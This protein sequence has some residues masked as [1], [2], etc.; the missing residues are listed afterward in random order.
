MREAW[1]ELRAVTDPLAVWLDHATVERPEAVVAK[2]DLLAAY[3]LESQRNGRAMT[4][5][6][7][8]GRAVRRLRPTIKEAQRTVR[9]RL[10]WVFVGIGLKTGC[11]K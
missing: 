1:Q 4:T 7:A 11:D 6:N 3:N 2:G 9:S 8:F 10:T 5:S